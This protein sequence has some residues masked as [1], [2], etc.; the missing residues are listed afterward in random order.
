M[1]VSEETE[2]A[3]ALRAPARLDGRGVGERAERGLSGEH[4]LR[5]VRFGDQR[6]AASLLSRIL[7]RTV[8]LVSCSPRLDP[9]DG[10]RKEG[11]RDE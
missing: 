8:A 6:D 1:R 4:D 10:E 5:V 2:H 7:D 11:N 9:Q 3:V